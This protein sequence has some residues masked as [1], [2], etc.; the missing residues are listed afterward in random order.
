[1]GLG[2]VMIVIGAILDFAVSVDTEGFNIN[3]IGLILLIVG[4]VAFVAGL[5]V[6]VMGSSRR[7]TVREDV[8]M[9]PGGGQERLAERQDSG[10]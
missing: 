4:I 3:T 6:F 8:R 2:I 5:A 9:T 7:T 10:I 1:M